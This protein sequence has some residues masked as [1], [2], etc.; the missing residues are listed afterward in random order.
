MKA[1]TAAIEKQGSCLSAAAPSDFCLLFLLS[2]FSLSSVTYQYLLAETGVR[3][4]MSEMI[5][6]VLEVL[7]CTTWP[8]PMYMVT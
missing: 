5:I 4:P 1:S 6:P 8:P 3:Y 7:A 2:V